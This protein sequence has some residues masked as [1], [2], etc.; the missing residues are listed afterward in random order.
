V[1]ELWLGSAGR[2]LEG[3]IRTEMSDTCKRTDSA[4]LSCPHAR[5]LGYQITSLSGLVVLFVQSLYV[6]R[7]RSGRPQVDI[8]FA[9]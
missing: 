9:R 7:C 5:P 3:E 2:W 8:Y 6:I 1:W 4:V